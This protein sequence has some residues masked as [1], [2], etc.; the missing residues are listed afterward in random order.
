MPR[1]ST[2]PPLLLVPN[3]RDLLERLRKSHTAP[4]RGVQRAQVLWL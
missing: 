1:R 4:R 3:E 2:R